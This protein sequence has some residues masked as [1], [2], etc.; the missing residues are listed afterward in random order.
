MNLLIFALIFSLAE[1]MSS[2]PTSAPGRLEILQAEMSP[3]KQVLPE[4]E[5]LYA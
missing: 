4:T 3:I 1:Q 5:G 2:V